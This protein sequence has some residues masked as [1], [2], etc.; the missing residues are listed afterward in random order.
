MT[1]KQ[2]RA[3]AVVVPLAQETRMSTRL[4]NERHY[5]VTE[6][7]SD[8]GQVGVGYSYTG[9]AGGKVMLSVIN[10]LLAP[11]VIRTGDD[12][13]GAC[14]E[15]MYRETLLLGRRGAVLRAM[16][17]L[18]MA[19]W[20]LRA[21]HQGVPLAV[22]LGG[23][24][25]VPVAAYASGG[26]YRPGE[27]DPVD[28][29][30]REIEANMS[31]GFS[32]HKIKVGGADLS[33]DVR[34]VRAACS[35]MAA[36]NRLA[37]DANNAYRNVPEALQALQAFEDAAGDA[38]L[39]WFEEPFAPDDIVAHAELR[40]K[41]STAIATGEIH[42][43]RFEF[44]ALA[45]QRA[46]DILQPDAGVVGGVGEWMRVAHLAESFGLGLAPHWH[47]NVH[48]H[49]AAATPS[50]LAI[51]HFALDKDIYNFE[52]LLTPDTR[53]EVRHGKA[54]IADRPGIGIEFD[55]GALERF[56]LSP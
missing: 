33:L 26:Y 34:R 51:E 45:D 44:Q 3:R 13:I 41:A 36:G 46:A 11:V 22:L 4:L 15:R 29:V 39:W 10:E 43:T 5:L 30:R 14:W 37:L 38:G 8:N 28:A 18:E 20:D 24:T 56:A 1:L 21:K 12:D 19:L 35:T 17:A 23:S 54:V 40:H 25:L 27:G 48:V 47:A 2:V 6:A 9:T 52:S 42:Q 53:L 55:P 31:A 50:C 32:D 49:L 7:I 16:S